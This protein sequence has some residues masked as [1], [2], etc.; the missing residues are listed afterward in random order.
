MNEIIELFS[1]GKGQYDKLF[2]FEVIVFF[3]IVLFIFSRIFNSN[4]S[5]II[6]LIVFG[7]Y[8]SNTFVKINNNN[9]NDTNK[10]LYYKL[11]SL[12]FI[13]YKYIDY[14]LNLI[15][16]AST[17]KSQILSKKEKQLI[18]EKNKLDSLYIDANMIEFLYSVKSLS[19]YNLNEFYLLLKGT[20]N[21]LKIRKEIEVYF[22]ANGYYP[23]NISQK[24]EIALDLKKNCINN[25]QNFIYSIPKT[26][27][28]Y[29]YLDS[30]IQTY[31]ILLNR[32]INIINNYHKDHNITKG[33]NTQTKFIYIYD[34]PKP[35][36]SINNKPIVPQKND[37]KLI[38][39]YI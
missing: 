22:N 21:I 14:K 17:N 20:N 4:Y 9:L 6:I 38:D 29:N 33:I 34:T 23:D 18:Y 32:N 37:F 11:Q 16:Y 3:I 19:E 30:S 12:Q 31:S 7:L 5:S 35:Y 8:L 27:L 2:Q 39:L 36:D 1:K 15:S 24:L 25:Y 13:T 28:M 10:Q 26:N